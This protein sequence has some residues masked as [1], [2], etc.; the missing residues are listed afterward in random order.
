MWIWN[1]TNIDR[2]AFFFVVPAC[3][4]KAR[5]LFNTSI[6]HRFVENNEALA[7]YFSGWYFW[8]EYFRR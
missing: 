2:E 3:T 8:P 4:N 1:A 6:G 7:F 5:H